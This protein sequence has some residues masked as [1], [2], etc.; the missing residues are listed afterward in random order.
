MANGPPASIATPDS[1]VGRRQYSTPDG[2]DTTTS[3][4]ISVT[5]SKR[6]TNLGPSTAA[7]HR[8]LPSG[9]TS[10]AAMGPVEGGLKSPAAVPNPTTVL[11]FSRRRADE[12]IGAQI[13]G[14]GRNSH[15]ICAVPAVW[16][17][18]ISNAQEN[19]LHQTRPSPLS[20]NSTRLELSS[21]AVCCPASIASSVMA[22]VLAGPPSLH[23][24][25]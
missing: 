9:L 5:G 13:S 1:H 25:D 20:N 2:P 23:S 6:Y 12:M 3:P 14:N 16:S 10:K 15:T 11:P 22:N 18:S 8:I 19:S 4:A 17:S 21:A 24:M 7:R